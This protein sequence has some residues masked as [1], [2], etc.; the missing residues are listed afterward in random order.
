MPSRLEARVAQH[1]REIA[2]IRKLLSQGARM[3]I[4]LEAGLTR[5]E[6]AQIRTEQTLERFI[7]SLE[8]GATNGHSKRPGGG[9]GKIQ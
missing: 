4:R 7:R 8:R 5:L 3:L 2:A 9:G 1:D 6:A